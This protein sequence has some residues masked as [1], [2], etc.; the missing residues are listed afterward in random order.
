MCMARSLQLLEKLVCYSR[1]DA[2]RRTREKK[3][4]YHSPVKKLAILRTILLD[5]KMEGTS[6]NLL[7]ESDHLKPVRSE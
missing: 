6:G 7:R 1:N 3:I 5:Y 2:T 4:Q